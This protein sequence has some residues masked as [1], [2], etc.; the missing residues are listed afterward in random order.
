MY[1]TNIW[2]W[3]GCPREKKEYYININGIYNLYYTLCIATI[4]KL[5]MLY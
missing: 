2:K 1:C 5:G 3:I 4:I